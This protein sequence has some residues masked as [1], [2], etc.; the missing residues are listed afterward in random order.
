MVENEFES[1]VEGGTRLL[2]EESFDVPPV[3][4][5]IGNTSFVFPSIFSGDPHVKPND[6][7]CKLR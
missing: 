6:D 2:L 4:L 3:A 7:L 1:S 5:D